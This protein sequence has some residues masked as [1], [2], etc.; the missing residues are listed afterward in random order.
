MNSRRLSTRRRPREAV[1]LEEVE[2]GMM[3]RVLAGKS[4]SSTI[5]VAR[6]CFIII[7]S[8]VP[9]SSGSSSF[10]GISGRRAARARNAA[11]GALRDA[12]EEDQLA[13][14]TPFG[15]YSGVELR[16]RVEQAADGSHPTLVLRGGRHSR[17]GRKPDADVEW[18]S[19][20]NS[21]LSTLFFQ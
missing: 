3:G 19:S 11:T 15:H 21:G 17:A 20:S 2:L 4:N 14:T 10:G 9:P 6:L 13:G 5:L 7:L 1:A 18:Q 16:A 8:G 12:G